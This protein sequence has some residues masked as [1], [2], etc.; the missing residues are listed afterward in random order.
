MISARMSNTDVAS[1]AA[2]G[3]VF[4]YPL[5]LMNRMRRWM[6]AVAAPDPVWMQA[7][8]NEF[9]HARETPAATAGPVPSPYSDTLRSS[10]WLDLGGGPV[11]LEVPETRGRF[12]VMSLIDLWTNV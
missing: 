12:Y 9:V 2:E 10:A 6:T 7:P 11:L 3:F 5:V 1:A 4:G 8:P